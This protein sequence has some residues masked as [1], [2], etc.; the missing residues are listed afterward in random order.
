MGNIH[1]MVMGPPDK[2]RDIVRDINKWKYEIEGK[3]FKGKQAPAIAE[4]RF[5]EVRL[6]EEL[7]DKFCRDFSMNHISDF[8]YGSAKSFKTKVFNAIIRFMLIFTPYRK[9]KRAEG[10]Q[11][12]S[13]PAWYYAVSL[14]KMKRNKVSTNGNDREVL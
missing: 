14:G 8:S 6:P 5:Y 11:Q 2:H 13:L 10:R 1:F 7:E 4:M 3:H 9:T 12:F